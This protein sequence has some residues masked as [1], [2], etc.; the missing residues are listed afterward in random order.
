MDEFRAAG[1]PEKIT[2]EEWEIQKQE[3]A[4]KNWQEKA[5]KAI[6]NKDFYEMERLFDQ[7]Y[8]GGPWHPSPASVFENARNDKIITDELYDEAMQYFGKLW[9]YSGD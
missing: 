7:K 9:N 4:E 2:P 6:Q 3:K 1:N 8:A 5:E